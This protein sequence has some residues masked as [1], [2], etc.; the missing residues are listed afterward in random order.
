MLSCLVLILVV[1][2]SC[3]FSKKKDCIYSVNDLIK[4]NE[5]KVIVPLNQ[6]QKVEIHDRGIGTDSIAGGVYI[7]DESRC[8]KQ[9]MFSNSDSS[10]SYKED[11]DKSGRLF[12]IEG[13]P[14]VESRI[15]RKQVDSVFLVFFFFALNKKYDGIEVATNHNDIIPKILMYKSKYYSNMKCIMI[16]LPISKTNDKL[17][18]YTKGSVTDTIS[19][20][21]HS[22]SDTTF[23]EPF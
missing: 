7:F 21:E 12:K 10:Y 17:E 15:I 22:F 5:G 14:I 8:L 16:G 13:T 4:N 1:F 18:I 9:Y 3:D 6:N 20:L 19:K 11:Y 23:F 2:S